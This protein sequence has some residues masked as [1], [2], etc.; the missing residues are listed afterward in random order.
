MAGEPK[1]LLVDQKPIQE[2]GSA[3]WHGLPM[4]GELFT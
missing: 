4:E 3:Q 2:S 1:E